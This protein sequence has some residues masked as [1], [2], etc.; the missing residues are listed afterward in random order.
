MTIAA[1]LAATWGGGGFGGGGGGGG[2]GGARSWSWSWRRWRLGATSDPA[3]QPPRAHTHSIARRWSSEVTTRGVRYRSLR[4]D[5]SRFDRS[6]RRYPPR[7]SASP[8][9]S[10]RSGSVHPASTT[11]PFARSFFRQ[12]FLYLI[13]EPHGQ[14]PPRR[15]LA[16]ASGGGE[17]EPFFLPFLAPPRSL[18]FRLSFR[19]IEAGSDGWHPSSA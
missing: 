7:T 9:V 1:C 15:G 16:F 19:R 17:S 14:S 5:R 11:L 18:S 2:G 8:D 3:R 4:F 13:P 10:G 6:V 12:H